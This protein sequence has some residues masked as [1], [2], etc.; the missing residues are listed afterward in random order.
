MQRWTPNSIPALNGKVAIVTG[1]NSGLGFD[2]ALELA[3]HGCR[4]I[5]ACR[6]L[7]KAEAAKKRILEAQPNASMDV[8][9]IDMADM[10]SVREFAAEVEKK[11]SS[12]SLL[13]NNA[14][15][16]NVPFKK[17]TDG[18][19]STFQINYLSHYL[20]TAL[21]YPLL[22]KDQ[23]PR[24]VTVS[25]M[26]HTNGQIIDYSNYQSNINNY[27][28]IQAYTDSKLAGLQ[29]AFELDRRLK[30]S[31][32][33]IISV[34]AHP[35]YAKTEGPVD[36]AG[37]FAKPFYKL[38]M[39]MLAQS[40]RMGA[41]PVL[42]AALA[43]DIK[44]GEY[45]GPNGFKQLGGLPVKLRALEAAYDEGSAKKLWAFSEHATQASFPLQDELN[46]TYKKS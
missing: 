38:T 13:I 16:F 27:K 23:S 32:K 25:S 12:I 28:S 9:H 37:F 20:L 14:G 19:E 46:V 26:S 41:L 42:Y 3:K 36:Y 22:V 40:A 33:K 5:M 15:V 11:Y 4:V 10:E 2:V 29:F 43:D 6:N 39:S 35:G 1:A 17:T 7:E 21:L 44:G 45:I 34:A 18:F 30:A 8:M 24:I 31:D